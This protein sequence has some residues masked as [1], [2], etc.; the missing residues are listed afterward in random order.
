[1]SNLT[2]GESE[3]IYKEH[4]DLTDPYFPVNMT[5]DNLWWITENDNY[6]V[7]DWVIQWDYLVTY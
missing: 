3:N 2:Y 1:M 5:P 4:W 6:I 7:T